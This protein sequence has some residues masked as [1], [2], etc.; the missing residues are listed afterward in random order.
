MNNFQYFD[1]DLTIN[2]NRDIRGIILPNQ[3]KM[4][5]ISDKNIYNSIC[6]VGIGAGYRQDEFEGTA[7]FLEHL[8][9]MGSEKYP[10]QNAY[11]SYITTSGGTYNAFTADNV[12]IYYQ[13]LESSFFKKGVDMLSCFFSKPLLDMKHIKS[14]MEIINSEHDKNLL[15]DHWIMDDL[16]KQFMKPGI[17]YNKFGTGNNESLKNITKEDILKFYNKYY[18]TCNM[19]VCIIDSKNIDTMEEE[20]VEFFSN[21]ESKIYTGKEDR[22]NKEPLELIKDNLIVFKSVSEYNFLNFNLIF[23][24]EETN[25]IDYQLINFICWLIGTEYEKS[26]GYYLK[27]NNIIDNL[28]CSIDYLMDFDAIVNLKFILVESK[29]KNIDI[30]CQ[31]FNNLLNDLESIKEKEFVKLY[32]ACQQI[33]LLNCMYL[34]NYSNSSQAIEIVENL[35]KGQPELAILRNSILPTY[36]NKI[37]KRFI[38]ILNSLEIKLITNIAYITGKEFKN[39]KWYNTKYFI[40]NYNFKQIDEKYDNLKYNFNNLIGIKDFYI[41]T[42]ILNQSIDKKMLPK[43]IYEDPEIKRKIYY[44]EYNKYKEPIGFISVIRYSGIEWND[45]IKILLEIYNAICFEILNYYL[46]SMG[47]YQMYFSLYTKNK[48]IIH[49]F[50]GLNYVINSFIFD[51]LKQIHP[52]TIFNNPNVEKYF[53]IILRNSKE[54]VKNLKYDAP[55]TRCINILKTLVSNFLLPNEYLDF[56]NSITFDKFKK[57]ILDYLKYSS[58]IFIIVGIPNLKINSEKNYLSPDLKYIIDALSLDPKRFF[59]KDFNNQIVSTPYKLEYKFN[60]N[61]ISNEE[62]NNCLIQSF[63]IKKIDVKY[64]NG[65]IQVESIKNILFNAIVVDFISKIIHDIFFDKVRTI[66]KLGY[67]IRCNYLVKNTG[68]NYIFLIS[69]LTQS[70]FS[71][72]KIK[73]SFDNFNKFLKKDIVKNKSKYIKQFT[74]LKKSKKLLLEKSFKNF[75]EEV[76]YYVNSLSNTYNKFN[77]N[78]LTLEV[79]EKINFEDIE[80]GIKKITSNKFEPNYIIFNSKNKSHK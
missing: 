74:S 35:F 38:E 31:A 56:L 73:E 26:I 67:I 39:S 18:T 69:Y 71:I 28:N 51:I 62:K 76:S 10:E 80:N 9:F 60:L 79:L 23:K 21:I 2:D 66:D 37:F 77:I 70:I 47:Q 65:E 13:E 24:A 68:N 22:F 59:V 6:A 53:N 14:E 36:N 25:L 20:Y 27:E 7:H 40:D 50:F 43:L 45:K 30:I 34:S 19:C 44:L 42:D 63:I 16:F 46:V 61:D 52:D 41:K 5:L 17:K 54:F 4:V 8:L 64:L 11:S 3:I 78:E 75:S 57:D 32:L 58:E 12:T 55:F 49:E 72:E 33:D 48:I 1:I 29:P 15:N